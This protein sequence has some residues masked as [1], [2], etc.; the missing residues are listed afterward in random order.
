VTPAATISLP[1]S[2]GHRDRSTQA[3]LPV[4]LGLT[5]LSLCRLYHYPDPRTRTRSH[6]SVPVGPAARMQLN[7]RTVTRPL[8]SLRISPDHWQSE[9]PQAGIA[10]GASPAS[11]CVTVA[12]AAATS[13]P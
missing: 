13:T 3:D 11:L 12:A 8:V 7:P 1:V 6:E 10:A 5:V 2:A 9:P 4:S